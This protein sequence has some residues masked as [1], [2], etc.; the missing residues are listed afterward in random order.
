V[1]TTSETTIV[2]VAITL[3]VEGSSTPTALNSARRPGAM[4]IPSA[5][6][7]SEPTTPSASPSPITERMTCPREAPS[8][9]SS[10][11]S[12][13]R[14]VTVIEKVLKMMKAPTNS[15]MPAKASSAV[16]RKLRPSWM[17][18]AWFLASSW[19]VRTTTER[20]RSCL[21]E[22]RSAS[23]VTP[24][25]AD[26]WIWSKPSL[27]SIRCASGSVRSTTTAP[28]NEST[29]ATCVVPTIVYALRGASATTATLSPSSKPSLSAVA[30]SIVASPAV[31]G[32][33]PSL[34][35]KPSKRG[36]SATEAT[37]FGAPP[38]PMRSPSLPST[39]PTSN[40][41][42]W[43]S[44]TS[45]FARTLARTDAGTVGCVPPFCD[46]SIGLVGV[47]AASVPLLDSLKIRSNDELMV[48]VKM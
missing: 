25:L 2:R 41:E 35:V 17:S 20:P 45:G 7:S 37:K 5:S 3:P 43:A 6:P 44:W 48:S 38:T 23:G 11:N 15:E 22:S 32:L 24:S 8:V 29:P 33:R 18:P 9:R 47:I 28:P 16:V 31:R 14:W 27:P 36:T 40:T 30:A 13:I 1:P 39:V 26:A 46:V 21:S 19:P 34:T 4:A 12:R 42:P 10:A